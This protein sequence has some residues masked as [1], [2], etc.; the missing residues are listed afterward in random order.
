MPTLRVNGADLYYEEH[1]SGPE[2][3]V[4]A[5]GLLWSG[6]MFAAQVRALRDRYRCVTFDF[7]G[8]G[9][10]EVTRGGYDMDMLSEDAATLIRAIG[11][12][13]CHF[14][15]LSM[16]GF[17]GMRLAIRHP[18]LL[19]SLTLLETSADPEPRRNV[20]R[21]ALLTLVARTVGLRPV[22]RRVM[23]IM[24]GRKFLSDPARAG[25]RDEL[26][27]ELLA[28]HKVGITRAT[29][30]VITRRGVYD[31][32]HRIGVPTLVGVGDQD[33]A[34][35]PAKAERIHARIPGSRLVVMPGAGHSSPIEEPE[36]V[37]AALEDFLARHS[38][39]E[40]AATA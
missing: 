20:P 3:V 19:R 35:V 13:P 24:F 33:V 36:A 6:R 8:Q 17:I 11:C 26:R 15:G 39:R 14:V 30:G 32:L 18:E 4:F 12:A 1:G 10:S 16:G 9:R 7:R 21:Y 25:L 37:N 31:Q 27:R 40:P 28:N 38:T 5:H 23:P 34:T 29:W 2:S 22:A